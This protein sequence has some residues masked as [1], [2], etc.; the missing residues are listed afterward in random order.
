MDSEQIEELLKETEEKVERKRNEGQ[1]LIQ[2]IKNAQD[3]L[4]KS[5]IELLNLMAE[6]RVYNKLLK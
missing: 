4:E 5:S 3:T 2:M 1:Q 6:V